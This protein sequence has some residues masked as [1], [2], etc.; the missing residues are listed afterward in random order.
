[1]SQYGQKLIWSDVSDRYVSEHV[2]VWKNFMNVEVPFD[3]Q[4]RRCHIHH[5]DQNKENND[6][7]NLICMTESDHH[8]WH[9]RNLTDEQKQKQKDSLKGRVISQ[10]QRE[11]ISKTLTGRKNK[12][13]SEETKKKN[14]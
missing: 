1:M 4:G 11:D 10:K 3:D 13:C 5:L 6:I 9:S 12:P 14:L 8:S 7:L 2:W